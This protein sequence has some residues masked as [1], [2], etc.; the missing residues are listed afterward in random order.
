VH[1]GSFC[2][3][4]VIEKK[5][6]LNGTVKMRVLLAD[7]RPHVRSALQI[8]LKYEPEVY[9]V[10]EANDASSLLAQIRVIHPDATLLDWELPGL[11]A[12][13]SIRALK[14]DF[15]HLSVIALSGRPETRQEALDAGADAFISKI[16]PPEQLLAALHTL[17][18][19]KKLLIPQIISAPQE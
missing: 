17:N 13:G 3:K 12:I 9:V 16:E 7:K 10:G 14:T 8:L 1:L 4:L 15:P 11:S 6:R 18:S 2:F 19:K 5:K